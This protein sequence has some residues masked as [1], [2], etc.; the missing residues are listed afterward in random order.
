MGPIS[1]PSEKPFLAEAGAGAGAGI[2][3]EAAL[4]V[5]ITG[6]IG[7]EAGE[8]AALS[9]KITGDAERRRFLRV[10]G[11]AAL[12]R[13]FFGLSEAGLSVKITGGAFDFLDGAA[14]FSV[15]I[16]AGWRRFFDASGERA[17]RR[18]LV[19]TGDRERDLDRDRDRERDLV[20]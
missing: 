1:S 12:R 10:S 7:L 20:A 5:K 8:A 11:E 14:F 3:L 13:L 4:S 18:F 2:G 16:T 15:K 17:W 6:G 9:V 19:A